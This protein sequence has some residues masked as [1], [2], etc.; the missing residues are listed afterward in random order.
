M[1]SAKNGNAVHTKLMRPGVDSEALR[2]GSIDAGKHNIR[3]RALA[4]TMDLRSRKAATDA[5]RKARER[6]CLDEL[7]TLL[8]VRP[9]RAVLNGQL[10]IA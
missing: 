1:A 4:T 9:R 5:A 10:A 7:E 6:A 2:Q 3:R 8:R